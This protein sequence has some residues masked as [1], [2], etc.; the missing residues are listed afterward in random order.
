M[1]NME[2]PLDVTIENLRKYYTTL[3]R[4]SRTFGIYYQS[5]AQLVGDKR[6]IPESMQFKIAY[7][8]KGVFV[9]EKK[10]LEINDNYI[11]GRSLRRLRN[12]ESDPNY[13]EKRKIKRAKQR[14][15]LRRQRIAA[16]PDYD[17]KIR[18]RAAELK[19]IRLEKELQACESNSL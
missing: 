4:V 3:A 10:Y 15:E 18:E 14:A 8:S 7:L 16:D 19:R 1:E 13:E 6:G 2:L 12:I 5:L 17:K 11:D 9:P